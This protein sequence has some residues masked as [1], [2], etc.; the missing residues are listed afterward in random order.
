MLGRRHLD[1]Q[2]EA[3]LVVLVRVR[4][5]FRARARARVRARAR[6]RVRE[7]VVLLVD[8]PLDEAARR[9]TDGEGV[10]GHELGLRDRQIHR[11][12]D[13]KMDGF[14]YRSDR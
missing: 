8:V 1:L 11:W 2:A 10:R 4:V 14:M 9:V 7:F 3:K 5:G 12:M 6:A 13:R